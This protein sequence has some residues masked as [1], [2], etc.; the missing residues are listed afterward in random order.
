MQKEGKGSTESTTLT[1]IF[2][3]NSIIYVSFVLNNN[4]A[5]INQKQ[6]AYEHILLLVSKILEG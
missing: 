3:F 5:L 4:I 1:F 6:A 2:C